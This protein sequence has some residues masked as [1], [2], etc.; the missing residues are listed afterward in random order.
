[1]IEAICAISTHNQQ[2]TNIE[3]RHI[4]CSLHCEPWTVK[5]MDCASVVYSFEEI[6]YGRRV[7]E[8]AG[9]VGKMTDLLKPGAKD[10]TPQLVMNCTCFYV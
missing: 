6:A 5:G 3:Q 9:T 8:T 2:L 1:M 7:N 10:G 4:Q